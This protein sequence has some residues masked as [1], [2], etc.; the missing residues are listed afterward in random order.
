LGILHSLFFVHV[1]YT[2]NMASLHLVMTCTGFEVDK[3][4]H[5]GFDIITTSSLNEGRF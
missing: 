2:P 1:K 3:S 4:V 5:S